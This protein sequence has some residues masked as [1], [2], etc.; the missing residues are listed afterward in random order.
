MHGARF[1]R[2]ASWTPAV[3]SLGSSG[4]GFA[5][6]TVTVTRVAPGAY[7]IRVAGRTRNWD[8]PAELLDCR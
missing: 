6:A 2:T 1:A 5:G 7:R 8:Y 3:W 4:G